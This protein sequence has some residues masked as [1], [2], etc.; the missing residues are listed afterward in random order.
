MGRTFLLSVLALG[1]AHDR[2]PDPQKTV[3]PPA[4]S[5][6]C[7]RPG[8]EDGDGFADCGDPACTCVELCS[9]GLDDDADGAV[10]CDDVDCD[11]TE[12]CGN[13]GDDDDDG[14][15]D[16]A[17]PDCDCAELCGNGLDDDHDRLIDCA[18]PD[19]ECEELCDNG[20]DDDG[21]GQI[22]CADIQ[23]SCPEVCDNGL[24]DDRDGRVDCA[25]RDCE[26]VEVCDNGVDDDADG[27][28]DCDDGDCVCPEVCDNGL[29]DDGNG[30]TDCDD[31]ACALDCAEWNCFDGV[32][33]D[34]DGLTDCDDPG[35]LPLCDGDGDGVVPEELGGLDCDDADPTVYGGAPDPCGDGRDLDCDGWDCGEAVDARG[36]LY[37][38]AETEEFAGSGLAAGDLDGDGVAELLA[39]SSMAGN[40]DEP[41]RLYVVPA[42]APAGP[43]DGAATRWVAGDE[44]RGGAGGRPTSGFDVDGDGRQDVM[45]SDNASYTFHPE[46]PASAGR[47]HLLHG[48]LDPARSIDAQA[49]WTVTH[50]AIGAELGLA[51][52]VLV[53]EADSVQAVAMGAPHGV[54]ESGVGHV[55]VF[56]DVPPGLSTVDAIPRTKLYTP[57]EASGLRI[58]D[59]VASAGDVDGDGVTDL[60]VVTRGTPGAVDVVLGPWPD[61]D[62][63]LADA[64]VARWTHDARISGEGRTVLAQRDINGDGTLD[65]VVTDWLASLFVVIGPLQFDRPLD[66]VSGIVLGV[67]EVWGVGASLDWAGDVTG[68][69]QADVF[70]ASPGYEA[71]GGGGGAFVMDV[72]IFG[73]LTPEEAAVRR[74]GIPDAARAG[75]YAGLVQDLDGDGL[76]EVAIGIPYWDLPGTVVGAV[77]VIPGTEW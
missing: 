4:L 26:C 38:A 74:W 70:L 9:N 24:D 14:L 10:D 37:T 44:P 31:R 49:R 11:C 53:G 35:C 63:L 66:G 1:C 50:D 54:P 19:C 51:T 15:I 52:A 57:G 65:A 72:P 69:G 45:C 25:D 58:G 46:R 39:Y 40:P 48:P 34:V 71:L 7:A 59:T 20:V 13:G 8:D 47:V 73:T 55:F 12:V 64:A 6:D 32:D 23:C 3:A 30:R 56:T 2:E 68:D 27:A 41:A 18:D 36:V 17:D 16:C 75:G 33:D 5:E 29:D 22:D 60:L 77:A 42:G 28:V 21:D 43:L 62:L 76:S 61:A 67:D